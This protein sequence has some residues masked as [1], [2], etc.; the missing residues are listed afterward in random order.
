MKWSKEDLAHHPLV[1][2]AHFACF[3]L[4]RNLHDA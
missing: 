2:Q 4:L 1:R 3:L